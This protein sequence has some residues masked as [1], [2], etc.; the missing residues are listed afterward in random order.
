M[1]NART[2]TPHTLAH[3]HS[4]THTHTHTRTHTHTYTHTHTHTHT[5]TLTV[6]HMRHASLGKFNCTLDEENYRGVI[7]AL[8]CIKPWKI[9]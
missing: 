7:L 6:T 8:F 3:T 4:L 2:R 9:D 1:L 5:H